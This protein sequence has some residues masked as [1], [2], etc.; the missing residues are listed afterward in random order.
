MQHTPDFGRQGEAGGASRGV[1][2]AGFSSAAL[3]QKSAYPVLTST[4]AIEWCSVK[5]PN[6]IVPAALQGAMCLLVRE[7][8]E[9]AT[10]R[11]VVSLT[12][13]K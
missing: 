6:V 1:S 3:G 9:S 11:M 7:S 13:T 12:F 5:M 10:C 2:A 8:P 4:P